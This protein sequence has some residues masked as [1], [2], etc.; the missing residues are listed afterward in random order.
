MCATFL[1]NKYVG[2]AEEEEEGGGGNCYRGWGL[3]A[4]GIVAIR[5][6]YVLKVSTSFQTSISC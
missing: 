2:N 1:M 5:I 3:N 4:S 6:R